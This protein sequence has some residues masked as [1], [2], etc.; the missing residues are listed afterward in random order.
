M[1]D[2]ASRPERLTTDERMQLDF[3]LGKAYADLKDYRR[4][5]DHLR[6]GAAAKRAQ[7]DY[8]EAAAMALFDRI[9]AAFP[10][11]RFAAASGRG[12]PSRT[13]IFILGM[14]RSGTTLVEQILASHPDVTGAG[15]LR[16]ASDV[17]GQVRAV[18]G[19][20]AHY[21]DFVPALDAATLKAMGGLYGAE[22]QRLAP[23]ARRITDKMPSNFYFVGLIHMALPNARILHT[24][25]DPL[26]TCLSCYSKLFAGEQNHTYDLGEL[27]RYHRRYQRLMD[28]WRGVLPPGRFLDVSYEALVADLEGQTR[29]ILAHCGLDWD[30]RCLSF[31]ETQR[32]VRTASASQVRRPIYCGSVGRWRAYAEDLA[33]LIE[34][35]G[36][37]PPPPLPPAPRG[38][39][40]KPERR[41]K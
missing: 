22:L 11:E 33:P 15:E 2:L 7:T 29:R 9:E 20:V 41:R 38:D 23:G 39:S 14:P 27:G 28:H 37:P 13:P 34:A 3:A 26:D 21:P 30:E 1:I 35:L 17:F 16:T 6:R 19:E 4:S 31:H 18:T 32:P 8:D 36:L 40:K 24:V 5:F 12:D 10:P 25:R